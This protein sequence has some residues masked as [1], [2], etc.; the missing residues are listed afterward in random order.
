MGDVD[1]PWAI[2]A[3]LARDLA[4]AIGWE[5]ADGPAA[6]AALVPQAV[7]IGSTAKLAAIAA[8][9]VPPGAE[10]E[11]LARLLLD[12]C[13]ARAAAPAGGAPSPAWSC[14]VA[15]TVMA[16]LV[17]AAGLGP[18]HVASTR[19]CDA[20][21]PMVDFHA[22]VVVELDGGASCICDPY[23]GVS[24][25]VPDGP[26][27]FA[28]AVGPLGTITAVRVHD[29]GWHYDLAM[30]IWDI[31]LRFRRLGPALDAG[32]V[33]AMA[34]VSVIYSGVPLRP[35]ARLHV[36]DGIADASEAADGTGVLRTWTRADGR[37]DEVVDSWATAVD[38]FAERTGT[39]VI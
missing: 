5:A 29:G 26:D 21:A 34:A 10:P 6:L 4:A 9:E 20:G 17:D 16:A 28:E 24:V 30:D 22:A 13:A 3:G 7:P 14:W 25:E 2:D 8:D 31:V 19:R 12:H 32:D 11:P 37:R 38:V 1:R 23:F 15:S 33:R 39:R 36:G 35:Y 27:G 18:V